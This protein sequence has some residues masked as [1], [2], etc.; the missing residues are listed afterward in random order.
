MPTTFTTFI[1]VDTSAG[2]K[3]FTYIALDAARKLLAVGSGSTVDVLSFALGQ[4]T[5]LLALSPL[6]RPNRSQPASPEAGLVSVGSFLMQLEL[7]QTRTPITPRT[8]PAGCPLW[9]RPSFALADQLESL[10]Y[11]AFPC[12]DAPLQWIE[13]QSE[14]AFHALLGRPPFDAG[15][16]EGRIQ[17]QLVLEDLDLDVP[18]AMQFFEEITRYRLLHGVLPTERIF[19]QV[20]LNA[21][22]AAQVAFL[23]STQ[24]DALKPVNQDQGGWIYLPR[25]SE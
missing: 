23:A 9:L 22:I 11:R 24:P 15:T 18:N 16:L 6:L 10:G 8:P 25:P 2:R 3:P 12:E 1:G 20:E 14:A 7:E 5:A 13:T 17:R 19:P 21:W 4:Q